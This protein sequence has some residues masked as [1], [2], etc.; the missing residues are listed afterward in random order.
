METATEQLT[1]IK[2]KASQQTLFNME[3]LIDS[4]FAGSIKLKE[5][6]EEAKA[7]LDDIFSEDE[8]YQEHL[9]TA[10]EAVKVKN[11]T[12]K[13][14]LKQ[15]Q[16]KTLDTKIKDLRKEKKE[17]DSALGDYGLQYARMTGLTEIQTKSG[18]TLAIVETAK[19]TQRG[20]KFQDSEED[21]S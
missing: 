19:V 14:I 15:G 8:T 5:Q 9:E 11:E 1:P 10:N 16:P 3:E 20:F 21:K 17:V 12:K 2:R 4:H 18:R 7:M 6:I 13:E